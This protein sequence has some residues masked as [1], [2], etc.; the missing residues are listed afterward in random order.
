MR[1]GIVNDMALAREVLRRLVLSVPGY[2]V[3]WQAEDGA[4][5]VRRAAEDRPDAILMDL[6][7]PVMD[8]VEA[9]R[10]IMAQSPCPILLVTSSV[11]GNYTKVFEAMGHGGLDAVN[12]PVLGSDGRIKDGEGLLKRLARLER[13]NQPGPAKGAPAGEASNPAEGQLHPLVALGASTGG[14]AALGDILAGLPASLP[15]SVVIVQHIGGEFVPGLAR[16]LQSRTALPVRLARGGDIPQPGEVLMAGHEEH[17]VMRPSHRLDYTPEPAG[18]PFQPSIDVFFNSLPA[19]WPRPG[20]AVL[21]TGMLSDG[22]Q[23]LAHLRQA[24]WLTLAQD[25]ATSVVYGMPRAA[26][27]LNAACRVLPLGD[28]ALTILAEVRRAG[29]G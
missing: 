21:L 24:G 7:M 15:A 19:G 13:L 22:A 2:S 25:E 23:G 8:G 28:M 29:R 14:P 17:L 27:E 12:I 6:V 11:S 26:A 3:A 4:V 1:I 20:V 5:A 9:T 18:G 10:R 16:W